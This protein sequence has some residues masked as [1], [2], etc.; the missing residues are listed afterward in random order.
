MFTKATKLTKGVYKSE[1]YFLF[2]DRSALVGYCV[3]LGLPHVDYRGKFPVMST[4]R[5]EWTHS[6]TVRLW[7][8][9]VVER[10]HTAYTKCTKM[11]VGSLLA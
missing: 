4:P 3:E 5:G 11:T 7:A 9:Q 2:L 8:D 6:S 1:G 10:E